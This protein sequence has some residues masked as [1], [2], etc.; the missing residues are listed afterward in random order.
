MGNFTVI[1]S[2]IML[3]IGVLML[4]LGVFVFSRIPLKLWANWYHE[5][6]ILQPIGNILSAL[7][8]I[9]YAIF[10]WTFKHNDIL[11]FIMILISCICAVIGLFLYI[12]MIG[13]I[14][15]AKEKNKTL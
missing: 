2:Y 4:L 6:L 11:A 12:R 13:L 9:C 10:L 5:A 1:A 15:E 7:F 8:L 3:I 14:R